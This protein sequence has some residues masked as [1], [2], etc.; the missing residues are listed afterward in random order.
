MHFIDY[1]FRFIRFWIGRTQQLWPIGIFVRAFIGRKKKFR[2]KLW[3]SSWFQNNRIS[4]SS[5]LFIQNSSLESHT[6]TH[7]LH[8]QNSSWILFS[9]K[10]QMNISY[11]PKCII[12]IGLSL[13]RFYCLTVSPFVSVD[14]NLLY[15][16]NV[17]MKYFTFVSV[18]CAI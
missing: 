16:F 7:T 4:F 14:V 8:I 11:Q 9:L 2:S 3:T 1:F 5:C 10:F 17:S 18:M 13:V 6:H 12:K 15:F